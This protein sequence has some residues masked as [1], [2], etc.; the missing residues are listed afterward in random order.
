MQTKCIWVTSIPFFGRARAQRGLVGPDRKTAEA[1]RSDVEED[2]LPLP[3]CVKGHGHG[4]GLSPRLAR[5]R[6]W[7]R[8][9][10]AS[11]A[12]EQREARDHAAAARVRQGQSSRYSG[13]MGL[14]AADSRPIFGPSS[15]AAVG[16]NWADVKSSLAHFA[17]T[18]G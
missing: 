12:V 6:R 15:S 9:K 18:E 8:R 2:E 1:S 14:Y 5:R 16:P 10:T 17:P 11:P 13:A 3:L 4:G 7:R